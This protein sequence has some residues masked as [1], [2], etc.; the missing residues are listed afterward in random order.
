MR[1]HKSPSP[2]CD[3][4]PHI[5]QGISTPY[6]FY[7]DAAYRVCTLLVHTIGGLTS[8]TQH[9]TQHYGAAG[10]HLEIHRYLC[11]NGS[12][13]VLELG[14]FYGRDPR[15]NVYI[16]DGARTHKSS[17]PHADSEVLRTETGLYRTISTGI[18]RVM[19]WCLSWLRQK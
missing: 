6:V 17:T 5:G 10:N 14:Q 11:Y 18:V 16:L 4:S 3:P 19:S 1:H 9:T 8:S 13:V 2:Q 15:L 7:G 12:I